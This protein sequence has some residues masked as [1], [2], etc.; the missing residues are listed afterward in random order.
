MLQ[1]EGAC[2]GELLMVRDNKCGEGLVWGTYSV[3][4]LQVAPFQHHWSRA[5]ESKREEVEGRRKERTEGRRNPAQA[6]A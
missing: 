5:W 6:E 4:Y 1:V 3:C 2:R